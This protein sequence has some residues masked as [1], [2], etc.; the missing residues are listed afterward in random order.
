M[1]QLHPLNKIKPLL[2]QPWQAA[3]WKI[4]MDPRW[5]TLRKEG[6][7]YFI[8]FDESF[9]TPN[10]PDFQIYLTKNTAPTQRNKRKGL[11][12]ENSKKHLGNSV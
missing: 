11:S 10:G 5:C 2:P 3:P 12:W 6:D 4:L 8:V 1:W 7:A 9:E